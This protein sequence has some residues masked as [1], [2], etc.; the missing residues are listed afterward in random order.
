M[1]HSR[2]IKL[3]AFYLPQFHPIP[4]NDEWWGKGFTEWTNVMQ[5]K[6]LFRGHYQ[7]RLPADLGF[8]DL[9]VPEV[10]E[11]QA[12]LA[13]DHGIDA[14]CYWHYWFGN[15]KRL[16]ERPFEEVLRTGRPDFPFCLGWANESWTGQ[17]NG[18]PHRALLAQRYPGKADYE[19]HFY[20]LLPAFR[21]SRYVRIKNR[22][23]FYVYKPTE[24]PD[25]NAFT[26]TWTECARREGIESFYFVAGGWYKSFAHNSDFSP[27][28]AGFD[29][30]NAVG[31]RMFGRRPLLGR[32][33]R[34]IVKTFGG[35]GNRVDYTEAV[36]SMLDDVAGSLPNLPT[37]LAGW[38]NTPRMGKEG[39]VL[40]GYQPETLRPQVTK[41]LVKAL[42]LPEHQRIVFVKSWN[43]WAEGNYLEPDLRFGLHFLDVIRDATMRQSRHDGLRHSTEGYS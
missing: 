12:K 33:K 41:A 27:E 28:A 17:W 15:G 38:D 35:F 9:R 20:S 8:Y 40:T 3:I 18:E 23:L 5:A 26:R 13:R 32:V 7:P 37:I 43:E 24:L 4:E 34:K 1:N 11:E 29:A 30:T 6:P 22:P 21:D 19:A 14:F 31:P 42:G 16:L 25:A 10:R 36:E 39:W 2:D